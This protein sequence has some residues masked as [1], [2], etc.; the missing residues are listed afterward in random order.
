MPRL[1]PLASLWLA[2]CHCWVRV[3]IGNQECIVHSSSLRYAFPACCSTQLHYE[4]G[5]R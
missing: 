1:P 3:C 4:T 2:L 5:L